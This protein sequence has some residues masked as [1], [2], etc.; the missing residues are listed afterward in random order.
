MKV[1]LRAERRERAGQA[2]LRAVVRKELAD[3][4]NSRRFGIVLLLV[5]VTGLASVYVAAQTIRGTVGQQGE[6]GFVFLRLFTTMGSSLPPFTAFLSFL[7]P[8]V[9]L[10]MG[11]DAI[12]GER[13]RNTLSRLL[14]QPIHRD[15]VINGKFLAGVAVL[16]VMLLSLGFLVGG[17]GL[18]LTGVPPTGEEIVRAL[19]FLGLTVVYVAFWLSLSLLFSLLFRQAATS[20]LAGIATWLFLVVFVGLL[21]GLVADSF[22]PV[23]EQ[24]PPEAVLRH[25]QWRQGLSR[26]SPGQLYD[27]AVTTILNPEVRAL[28][29]ILLE[30]AQGAILGS[31]LPLGQSLLLVWP[32]LTGLLAATALCFAIAYVVFMRQEIRAG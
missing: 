28:G 6:S 10:A 29:P 12:N 16:A 32:H 31:A 26:L 2:G 30:Q 21:A 5:A 22:F 17:L 15:A 7:G 14:A 20:A 8:L 18:A 11:F 19:A 9:G 25:E 3:H 24:S 4:L 13:A 27:E 1:F 23:T